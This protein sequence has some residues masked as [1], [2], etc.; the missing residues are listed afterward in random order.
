MLDFL[1]T[2][3][4]GS[5]KFG[6]GYSDSRPRGPSGEPCMEELFV[7]SCVVSGDIMGEAWSEL[8]VDGVM[9]DCMEFV[10]EIGGRKVV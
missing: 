7:V 8:G 6:G 3:E 1:D 2:I 5:S 9:A 4:S 10:E